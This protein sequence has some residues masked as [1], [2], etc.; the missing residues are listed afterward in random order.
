MWPK[1]KLVRD[2][3]AFLGFGNFYWQ[4]IYGF[5]CIAT[6]LISML[7]TPKNTWSASKSKKTKG[8]TDGN[9]MDNNIVVSDSGVIIQ[10]SPIK[11]NNLAKIIKSKILI[12]SKNRD[13]PP[14]S[15]NIKVRLGFLIL[16][17]RL[18]FIQVRQIFVEAL[19][20]YHF[21]PKCHIRVETN[22]SQSAISGILS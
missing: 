4:F 19:I 15:K 5:S 9:S 1:P 18:A 8:K 22:K 20:L 10:I 3:Q 13:F 16:K 7:K 12:K 2:I 11:R 6:S 14:N 21:N 17:A